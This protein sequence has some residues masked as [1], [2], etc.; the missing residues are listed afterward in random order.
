MTFSIIELAPAFYL[1]ST[2]INAHLLLPP[3]SFLYKNLSVKLLLTEKS[4]LII[5]FF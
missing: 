1:Q 5:L 2:E 3:Y 4:M